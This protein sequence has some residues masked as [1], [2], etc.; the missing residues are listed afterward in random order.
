MYML[1]ILFL[2][3]LNVEPTDN[4]EGILIYKTQYPTQYK[5]S[6]YF[7]GSN[8]LKIESYNY[9]K[10]TIIKMQFLYDF[11][12]DYVNCS[13]L[14]KGSNEPEWLTPNKKDFVIA[15]N[16][17]DTLGSDQIEVEVEYDQ[18]QI[19]FAGNELYETRI[20]DPTLRIELPEGWLLTGM[21]ISDKS[22]NIATKIVKTMVLRLNGNGE[23]TETIITTELIARIPM[24]LGDHYFKL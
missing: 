16:R 6:T 7:I 3:Q 1:I 5:I 4:F 21:P 12:S 15:Y 13:Y 19:G 22:R 23:T 20:E 11:E 18:S 17:L 2:L 14:K 24:K 10:D 9:R 8:K